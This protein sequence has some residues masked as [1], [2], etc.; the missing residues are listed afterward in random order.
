MIAI[1]FLLTVF[2][3]GAG[4]TVIVF[5]HLAPPMRPPRPADSLP[6]G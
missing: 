6:V 1:R 4:G 3:I 2:E 5:H